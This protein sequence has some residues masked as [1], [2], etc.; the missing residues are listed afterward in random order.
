MKKANYYLTLLCSLAGLTSLQADVRLPAIFSDHAVLQNSSKVPVWGWAA[1]GEEVSVT[2]GSAKANAKADGTG[3]WRAALDLS[4]TGAGPF[5]LLVRG[6]NE[7]KISDVLVGQVWVCAGQ[8][9]MEMRLSTTKATDIIAHAQNPLLRHFKVEKKSVPAPVEDVV[10]QWV[11][12]VPATVGEFTAVGYYFGQT[13]QQDLKVPV[14]LLN[15]SWGGS[16][17]ESWTSSEALSMQGGLKGYLE[18][19]K[20][21]AVLP[22]KKP[23]PNQVPSA[24]FNGM[25]SPVLPYGIAGAIWYQGESNARPGCS[26]IYPKL[27][28]CMVA[29]W[30][31]RWE[32]GEFP[33]YLCQLPNFMVKSSAPAQPGT[34]VDLRD[35]QSQFV[36]MVPNTGQAI[37]IDTGAAGD[38]HPINKKDPGE[39]LARIALAKKYGRNIVH[40]GPVFQSAAVENDKMRLTF[41]HTEGGLVAKPLPATYQP[42]LL[43][44]ATLPLVRNSPDSELEGFIICGEDHKWEWANAKIDGESVLVWSPKVLK[45]A[46]LR[47][48]WG[49]NPTCN[50]YNSSELPAGPFRTD[51]FPLPET[52]QK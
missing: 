43:E 3:K 22:G 52:P 25:L 49:S 19:V 30:R 21:E 7:L 20:A 10:G 41:T 40:S 17:A 38:L 8:S 11:S 46:A 34:W 28:A 2:L 6:N 37:L 9:N 23:M 47:Y 14:G 31:A 24:L 48:A 1:A 4:K 26:Q 15:L 33:F 35:A 5:D 27:L 12:A 32:C 39:R 13:L 18:A 50:L 44:P 36:K 16:R 45:P 42:K 29:D 51:D